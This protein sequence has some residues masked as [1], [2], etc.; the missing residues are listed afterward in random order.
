MRPCVPPAR[1][2]STTRCPHATFC[3]DGNW[4]CSLTY[5]SW[6]YERPAETSDHSH[7]QIMRKVCIEAIAQAI[8]VARTSRALRTRTT[9]A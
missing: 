9:V 7:E 2:P 3:L 1:S 5:L 8:A 6:K 4:Q